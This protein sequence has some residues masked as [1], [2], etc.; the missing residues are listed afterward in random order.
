[1]ILKDILVQIDAGPA[2]AARLD[3]AIRLAREHEAHLVGLCVS[4]IGLVPGAGFGVLEP[5]NTLA[6][7]RFEA[8]LRDEALAVAANLAEMFNHRIRQDEVQGEWRVVE[9]R[10]VVSVA[11]HARY[12][13]LAILGQENPGDAG[14]TG[15][16]AVLETA[17]LTSGRPI[18]VVPYAGQ[19]ERIGRRVLVGWNAHREAARAVHDALPLIRGAQSVTVLSVDSDQDP[20]GRG[21]GPA[22]DLSRH[23]ARHGLRVSAKQTSS[24]GLDPTDVL[25]NYAAD[26]SCD[27][28]VVGGY[29]HS[30]MREIVL[31]GVTRGLL[32]RAI[33]PVLMS[34]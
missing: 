12:A 1:M 7:L 18:L 27:L 8:Q 11:L 2:T 28:I 32:Q 26:E 6:L 34:H 19:F 20:G 9:G 21:E 30:R 22:A 16:T 33:V 25:L 24:G 15:W 13:D 5:E 14:V 10:A 29:G 4:G 17:L 31:G 3:L 23:L